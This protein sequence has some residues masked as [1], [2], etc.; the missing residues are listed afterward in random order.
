MRIPLRSDW[1]DHAPSKVKVYPLGLRDRQMVDETFDKLH[2]QERLA[3]TEGNTAFN[4][5]CF[6]VWKTLADG[7]RV[8][9]SVVNI[10]AFNKIARNDVHPVSLQSDVIASVKGCVYLSVL[11]ALA[12]FYHWRVHP[13]DRH[14]LTVVTHRGQETFNVAVMGYKGSVVYVQRQI[15]RILRP[16]KDFFTAYVDD[17]IVFFRTLPEH[18]QHLALIFQTFIETGIFIKPTKAFIGFPS[19][20]LLGQ[21]VDS[22]GLATSE[23]KIRIISQLA[24]PNSLRKLEIYLGLTDW[25][26]QYCPDYVM[27]SK[28]F[29]TKKNLLLRE[30]PKS[31]T[32]RKVFA[33]RAFYGTITEE[34][35]N[36]YQRIQEVFSKSTFLIHQD[37][38]RMIFVDLD[39][40]KEDIGGMM[41]HVKN[42]TLPANL[43]SWPKEWYPARQNIESILFLSRLINDVESR[44]WPTEFE[45]AGM[46]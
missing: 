17:I 31:G 45:I 29:Q 44:Y 46:V 14:K 3:W 38:D 37:P 43:A 21:H 4:Y 1:E 20:Q 36:V 2:E 18:L 5:P 40:S 11:D 8:G 15:N 24:F 22:L 30:T 27:I 34:E 9:R 42:F 33:V 41:Y 6:V 12:F 39:F 25:L 35:R 10:R 32:P 13:S 28:P 7:K 16:Y 26:R 19:M 23:E